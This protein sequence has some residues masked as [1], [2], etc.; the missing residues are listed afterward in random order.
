MIQLQAKNIYLK[1]LR[2]KYFETK[3]DAING[4]NAIIILTEWKEFR[5]PDFD[6]MKDRLKHNIIFDGRNIYND[7]DLK[8]RGWEYHQIGK[9]FISE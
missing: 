4:S 9:S 5:C 3:Y 1:N 8:S 7:F 2:V 6:K